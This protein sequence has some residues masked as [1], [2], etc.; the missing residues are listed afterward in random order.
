[1][2]TKAIV[3]RPAET[4]VN[5]ITTANLG[6]PDI[7]LALKQHD[8]YCEALIKCGLELIV[9]DADSHFPDSCFV[10]DT[11]IVTKDFGVI[12]RPGDIRRRGEEIEIKKVL[13]PLLKLYEIEEPGTLDGGDVMQADQKFY[14]GI[15]DRTNAEGAKQLSSFLIQH[16]YD[17]NAVSVKDILHFKTGINYLGDNNL[18]VQ[19]QFYHI[20]ELAGYHKTMIDSDEAYAAN[21]LRV[22]NSVLVP[23]GFPKTKSKIETLGY[24]AIEINLSEFQKLDGGLSCLSLRF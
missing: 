20:P 24:A 22:N 5:G 2:F 6:K 19:E 10:E 11:A 15:S 23:K 18:L 21:S 12:S 4:F 13:E 14:I 8:A 16:H 3:R 17:A 9:L 7:H 1:M